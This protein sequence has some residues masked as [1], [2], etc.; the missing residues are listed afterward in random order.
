MARDESRG[1]AGPWSQRRDAVQR[2]A[3]AGK[4][5]APTQPVRSQVSRDV[6]IPR[7]SA[8]FCVHAC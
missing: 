4:E 5:F 1:V 7:S 6:K 3:D 8:H 2:V